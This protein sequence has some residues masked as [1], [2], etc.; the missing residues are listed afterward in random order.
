MNGNAGTA[1]ITIL[2]MLAGTLVT[3]DLLLAGPT[4]VPPTE[5]TVVSKRTKDLV[6]TI[7][8]PDGR[9]KGGENS[10]C[11][12]FQKKG[13]EE[14][15]NVQNVS[16]DFTLLV[17]RIQENP[18]RSPLTE[19]QVGRYCGQVNLGKQ[20]YIPASYYAFVRYTDGAGKKRKRRFFLGVR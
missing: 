12:V 15:V 13:T 6:I 16:V 19:G 3:P 8:S 9:L 11:V 5:S 20:Y 10:F 2:I 4:A 14:P 1:L 7:T 17:G 18:I